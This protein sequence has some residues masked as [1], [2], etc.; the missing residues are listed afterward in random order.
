MAVLILI[1]FFVFCVGALVQPRWALALMLLMY[2][3]EQAIQGSVP[4]FI[5][6]Q[7]LVNYI[8]GIVVVLSAAQG[9]LRGKLDTNGYLNSIWIIV[10]AGYIYSLI[11]NLWTP[12]QAKSWTLISE[13]YQYVVMYII[14]APMLVGDIKDW[15]RVLL[16]TMI[17][18]LASAIA[19]LASPSFTL[20]SGRLGFNFTSKIRSSPLA[21]GELGGFLILTSSLFVSEQKRYW[22]FM[23]Q[24]LAFVCGI[25][26]SIFSGSRGQ[27]FF[28]VILVI[29]FFPL[30]RPIK[31][32]FQFF[33]LSFGSIALL[34]MITLIGS[35]FLGDVDIANRWLNT[36]KSDQAIGARLANF[37][38]LLSAFIRSPSSWVLGLGHNAFTSATGSQEPYSHIMFL[39]VLVEMGLI[40]FIILITWLFNIL[41]RAIEL[42]RSTSTDS[43]LRS[44]SVVLVA[45]CAYQLLLMNKQ[46]EL[47][48]S[49]NTIVYFLLLAK[50]S[51]ATRNEMLNDIPFQEPESVT[52]KPTSPVQ[53]G[54]RV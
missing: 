47:W 25:I 8:I 5:D 42:V 3:L 15:N 6:Q 22:I 30:S 17:F 54:Y 13:G 7:S 32:I 48:S 35:L 41:A 21:I 53:P 16:I 46:G 49:Q 52:D 27:F 1:T 12:S 23:L 44:A 28:S 19:I 45:L 31:N 33:L 14:I 20:A 2:P 10:V 36:D 18:G 9:W 34:F 4:F 43:N 11:S 50:V 37:I 26:L 51:I 40:A 39:D 24:I 38:E 29:A